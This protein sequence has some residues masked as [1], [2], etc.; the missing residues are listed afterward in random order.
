M[1]EVHELGASAQSEETGAR[2][3]AVYGQNSWIMKF[4]E[5][6]QSN[7]ML[8]FSFSAWLCEYMYWTL[9]FNCTCCT[10]AHTLVCKYRGWMLKLGVFSLCYSQ[11]CILLQSLPINPQISVFV[12]QARQQ[13]PVMFQSLKIQNLGCKYTQPCWAYS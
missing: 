8:F 11:H 1:P 4:T 9:V 13:A 10:N 3:A 7:G 6:W 2:C 12:R 5:V